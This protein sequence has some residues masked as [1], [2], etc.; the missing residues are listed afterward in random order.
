[1]VFQPRWIMGVGAG[2]VYDAGVVAGYL[3]GGDVLEGM[4][5]GTAA[6]SLYVSRRFSRFPDFAETSEL[7]KKVVVH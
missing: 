5:L 4:I 2:D 3:N 7:A 1:M 6:A